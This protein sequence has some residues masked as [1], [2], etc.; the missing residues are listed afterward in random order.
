M[1]LVYIV[2]GYNAIKRS[3]LFGNK[4]LQA[5]RNHFF[6][7]L[8]QHRPQGS[9]RNR[10]IIVF[11]GSSQVFGFRNAYSF[12]VIFT[13]G[14]TA[15][16]K[17][18]E[19]VDTSPDPKNMVVVTDDKALALSVRSQGAKIMGTQEFLQKKQG[20]AKSQGRLRR[21]QE[22]ETKAELNIVQREKI[23]QEMSKIW[24]NKR[25]S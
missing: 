20:S 8:D 1:S 11:D 21:S 9:F 22:A 18:K 16:E 7:Y 3:P 19:I 24:L 4:N 12:E 25:S 5:A 13:Q 14:E 6:S 23:T 17:I 10:L 2:D 15:D